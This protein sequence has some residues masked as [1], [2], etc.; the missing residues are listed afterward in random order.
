M[1]RPSAALEFR[2][3]F[4]KFTMISRFLLP[5]S[6]LLALATVVRADDRKIRITVV[7]VLASST[8][9]EVDR[10]LADLAPELRKKDPSW[11]GFKVER[12][13]CETIELGGRKSFPLVDD[14]EVVIFVKEREESGCV[15]LLIKPATLGDISY[16]CCCDKF[17]PVIT[18]YETRDKK[19]LVIAV[20]V[21]SSPC[22]K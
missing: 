2:H 4:E 6:V 17:F 9:R 14:C 5:F 20:L 22:K 15:R 12:V 21:H 18:R 10:R 1:P 19:R 13:N 16:S 7:A 11:T 3:S 8:D